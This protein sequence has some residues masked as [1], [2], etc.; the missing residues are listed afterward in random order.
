MTGRFNDSDSIPR[1]IE[2]IDV[3]GSGMCDD[4]YHARWLCPVCGKS[5]WCAYLDPTTKSG[6]DTCE[7]CCVK[8]EVVERRL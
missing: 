3:F 7:S 1:L 5:N 2:A 6:I 4:D 8:V